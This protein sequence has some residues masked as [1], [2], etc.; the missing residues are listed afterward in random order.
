MSKRSAVSVVIAICLAVTGLTM[1]SAQA[2]G[3]GSITGQVFTKAL[4]ASA[5]PAETTY[6][7]VAYSATPDGHYD[8]VDSDPSTPGTD[9][10]FFDGSTYAL[11]GLDA[12]YYKFEVAGVGI[13]G[14]QRE[15][16]NDAAYLADATPIQV[17][18]GPVQADDMVIEPAGQISGRVTD[19]AGTPLANASVS[20]E[21]TKFGGSFGVQTDANGYYSTTT[22][23]GGGLV[24]GDFRVS[25]RHDDYSDPD[26]ASHE[27]E[28]WNNATS[29][30]TAT[31]VTVSPGA[32]T[33][34]IDFTLDVAPRL[35]L[36][37]KDPDGNP[38]PNAGVGIWVFYDG[39][40]GPY[41]AGPN[42]TDDDGIYRRNL[43][44]GD[45]FKFFIDPPAGVGGVKEWYDNAYTEATASEVSATAHG[46]VVIIEI[47]LGP[48]PA[49]TGT[50]PTISGTPQVD[51]VLTAT[52][53][54]WGP[55]GVSLAYQ[56]FAGADE[57]TGATNPTYTPVTGDIG[58]AITVEV[59]RTLAG[60]T[61]TVKTSSPTTA[62]TAAPVPPVTGTTP[63]ISGT[64]QV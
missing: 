13:A 48:A 40:W 55:S 32:T 14:Y 19:T 41:Q 64:P 50:T 35:R 42:L 46:Q 57:I 51:Q 33:G 44:I 21:R 15:Y 60:H 49:V 52:P 2:A 37:V 11:T 23:F 3:T 54:A 16:Y 63:T 34:S 9:G 31:P 12:G 8:N 28:Y 26:A 6:L 30:D 45:R 61:T 27:L 20:F 25:A 47:K 59:T 18:S 58:E 17:G 4:G 29:Y 22:V 43:R 38:V 1:G 62:V 53:G 10:F 24:K 56:W 5:V 39:A 7:Y 36:T